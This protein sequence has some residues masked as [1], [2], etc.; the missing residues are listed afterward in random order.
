MLIGL[1]NRAQNQVSYKANLC[2][3]DLRYKEA[4]I[5]GVQEKFQFTPKIEDLDSVLAPFEM[6]QLFR[7]LLPVH[8]STGNN[9]EA[10]VPELLF[11]NVRRCKYRVNLHVHTTKSDGAMTP[12]EYL[13]QSGRYSNKVARIASNDGLPPYTSATTDHNNMDAAQ[14]VIAMIADEPKKY[15]NFKFVSGCEFMFLDSKSGFKFPAFEAVGLGINPFS[16][17][18]LE[19][20]DKFN[21][22][23]IIKKLVTENAVVSYAH[24]IRF[25]QGN[26]SEPKFI[27]YLKCLGING[28][29]SNYQYLGFK[30]TEKLSLQI[31][32]SKLIA[33]QNNFF[34]TGGTDTH[35]R[36]IFHQRAQSLIDKLL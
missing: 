36:N 15:K 23:E 12:V 27:K 32:E 29:E 21:P 2:P 10:D 17:E 3:R 31:E 11:E 7:K 26:G 6:Q 34:E 8:F 5:R 13:E 14:E 1:Y 35:G 18:I 19:K 20:L 28:I 22:V 33:K 4:L 25:C 24:P 9:F 16:K 30:N